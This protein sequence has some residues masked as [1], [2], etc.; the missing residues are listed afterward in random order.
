MVKSEIALGAWSWGVGDTGGDKVFG[1]YLTAEDLKPVFDK[2]IECG[3]NIWDTA[4]IRYGQL[5]DD[6]RRIYQEREPR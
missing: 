4:R 2:A 5:R 3:L 1:N 6:T